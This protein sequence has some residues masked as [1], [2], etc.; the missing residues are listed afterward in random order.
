MTAQLTP[1]RKY[2]LTKIATGDYLLPSNDAANI[3]RISSYTDG[4][5]MGLEDW[6]RD[7]TVWILR[8]WTGEVGP[9]CFVDTSADSERWEEVETCIPTRR[10]AINTALTRP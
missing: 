6:P 4:P 5:S 1:E 9:G 7:R 8:R 10:E 2:A 3:Y